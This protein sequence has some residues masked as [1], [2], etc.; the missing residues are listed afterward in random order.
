[1]HLMESFFRGGKR[2]LPAAAAAFLLCFMPLPAFSEAEFEGIFW[3]RAGAESAG[4]TEG[5]DVSEIGSD[6]GSGIEEI[7]GIEKTTED[8]VEELAGESTDEPSKEAVYRENEWNYVDGWMD[9]S[10]GIPEDALGRLG[11]IREKGVLTVATEP[12]YAPQEFVDPSLK[13]QDMYVGA[14][15]ELA[16]L[17]AERMGV[18]LEIVPMEFTKVL[19]AVTAGTCDL[20]ISGLAYTP[21]RAAS[22]TMSMGYHYSKEQAGTG[23]LIREEDK[24]DIKGI[25]DLKDRDIAAQSGSLQ[26]MHMA[27]NVL[28]YRQFY[29]LSSMQ[30][31][32]D[33][34]EDGRADA[35]LADVETAQMYIE[36]NPECGLM[37]VDDVT[38]T[39][40]EQLQGDRVAAPKDELQLVYF[41]NGVI[42]EVLENG[43]YEKWFEEYTL[44]A[45]EL[46]L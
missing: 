4:Q 19:S 7:R 24:D 12:D 17:I 16:R 5:T 21:G 43:Q 20:A 8:P 22:M 18:E 37:L 28:N 9:V 11:R 15:M 6:T 46:G 1:M 31:V 25:E 39:L 30:E 26:E 45:S 33:F 27:E 3:L 38:F 13:G 14:D 29:R 35:A 40:D 32:Y 44:L 2:F 23:I 42:R 36:S 41:V 10:Q 34:L